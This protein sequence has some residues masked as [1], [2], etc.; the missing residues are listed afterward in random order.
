MPLH[1]S[2][3]FGVA[4]FACFLKVVKKFNDDKARNMNLTFSAY[5]SFA[6][7]SY[8]TPAQVRAMHFLGWCRKCFSQ[9]KVVAI[10][11]TRLDRKRR[12]TFG[13]PCWRRVP[14]L[15]WSIS[16]TSCTLVACPR[17]GWVST[18]RRWARRK[19]YNKWIG[20]PASSNLQCWQLQ[21]D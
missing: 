12:R 3:V 15:D 8:Q 1:T 21:I 16:D 11:P 13:W 7:S 4:V 9:S 20:N 6:G 10:R 19:S 14:G 2:G 17:R 18:W 5:L